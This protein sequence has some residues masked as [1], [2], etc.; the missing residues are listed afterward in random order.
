[1]KI[2]KNKSLGITCCLFAF[3]TGVQ[4]AVLVGY[5]FDDGSGSA[6]LS[7]T[8]SASGVTTSA[9]GAGA[10]LLGPTIESGGVTLT[11]GEDAE[12]N[13][14]GTTNGLSL[15]GTRDADVGYTRYFNGHLTPNAAGLTLAVDNN[16][17]YS[18][19]LT[20]TSGNALNFTSFTFRHYIDG[21]ESPDAWALY[22]SVGGFDQANSIAVG[23]ATT[24]DSWD[25]AD[26]NNVIDLSG[27]SFQGL[28]SNV[29][30]RLVI[31][32]GRNNSGSLSY[33]DNF[34]VNGTVSPVPEPS[35]F[36]LFG[37]GGLAFLTR[38]RR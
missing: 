12:G 1:M 28:E 18:F 27:A 19:T 37:L 34:I 38:R 20:P 3:L 25:G 2:T 15:G 33:W 6:S 21:V 10:G 5:D 7:P 23:N 17:Y 36:A 4:A 22:S 32:N 31:Y 9:F 29:E 16:D 14:F 30:F 35:T 13:P 24:T 26:N 8:V 11:D